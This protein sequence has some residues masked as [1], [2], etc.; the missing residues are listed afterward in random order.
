MLYTYYFAAGNADLFLLLIFNIKLD[1]ARAFFYDDF[2]RPFI[3]LT[4]FLVRDMGAG[5][6]LLHIF[7]IFK[8]KFTFKSQ[9][10]DKFNLL[11]K[12]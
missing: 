12:R 7:P 10:Y 5:V 6:F 4:H 8:P 1:V 9:I 11:L 2:C 3:P